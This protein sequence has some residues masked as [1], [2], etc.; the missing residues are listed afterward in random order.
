MKGNNAYVKMN[1][2]ENDES[3]SKVD[4]FSALTI[5]TGQFQSDV[6]YC[7]QYCIHNYSLY[8]NQ[9]QEI[10]DRD[11]IKHLQNKCGEDGK[12]GIS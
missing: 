7:V 4:S 8:E 1:P 9:D 12:M 5:R 3:R 11:T 2:I 10:N 6:L